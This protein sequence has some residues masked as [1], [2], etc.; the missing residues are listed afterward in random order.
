V[1][2]FRTGPIRIDVV[3][4]LRPYRHA[5]RENLPVW[6]VAF[7]LLRQQIIV[8]DA[9]R[10]TRAFN[11][12]EQVIP[13]ELS[14][15]LLAQRV[16]PVGFPI[17]FV[18]GMAKWQAREWSIVDGW[19]LMNAVWS[20]KAPPLWRLINEYP[21]SAEEARNAYRV[22]YSAY[23][24]LFDGRFDEL[25]LFLDAVVTAGSF[26]VGFQQFFG[27]SMETFMGSFQHTLARR[28][29]SRLLVFQTGPLFSLAA[30]LFLFVILRH[31]L[32]KRRRMKD[33]ERL[34]AG[35]SLDDRSERGV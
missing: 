16:G 18:E 34:E 11:S 9:P 5:F 20:K 26:Q 23:T 24:E 3:D 17:W 25:P 7:A 13:H 32:R 15:I 29:H 2:L 10:A 6:G 30:V 4:D 21:A 33:L 1:G 31:Q 14:H 35:L 19:Q 22:S 12:L 27:V 8:V 28:Y